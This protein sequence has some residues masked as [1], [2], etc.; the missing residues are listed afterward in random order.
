M[1]SK[2]VMAGYDVVGVM[3]AE[4]IIAMVPEPMQRRAPRATSM[5]R[6]TTPPW[7]TN[8]LNHAD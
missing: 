1:V 6:F 4:A 7:F 2:A 5:K 3:G 8:W